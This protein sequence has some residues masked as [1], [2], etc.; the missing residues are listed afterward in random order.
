[1]INLIFKGNLS[2][3]IRKNKLKV[4]KNI[5][6]DKIMSVLSKIFAFKNMGSS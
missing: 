3:K 6:C 4:A 5:N 1:M 2:I